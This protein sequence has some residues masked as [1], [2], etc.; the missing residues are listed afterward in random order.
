MSAA[1]HN[2]QAATGKHGPETHSGDRR[3]AAPPPIGRRLGVLGLATVALLPTLVLASCGGNTRSVASD[4]TQIDGFRAGVVADE[5]RAALIGLLLASLLPAGCHKKAEE[6]DEKQPP[7]EVHCAAA[8]RAGID[9]TVIL[10]GKTATPP[11]GDLPVED[12]LLQLTIDLLL[13]RV[14]GHRPIDGPTLGRCRRDLTVIAHFLTGP[15]RD[16]VASKVDL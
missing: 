3:F 6:E 16:P 7:V 10:R 2:G 14:T 5:P 4:A 12:Q 1:Y 9:E 11:G 8:T 13:H 15:L